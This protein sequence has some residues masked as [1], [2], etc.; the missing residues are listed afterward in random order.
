MVGISKHMQQLCYN[1]TPSYGFIIVFMK[2]RGSNLQPLALGHATSYPTI[3]QGDRD[4]AGWEGGHALP[5]KNGI[6]RLPRGKG[7][8]HHPPLAL[9]TYL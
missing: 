5:Q 6:I 2:P 7:G 9:V 4:G 1:T 8:R 3:K